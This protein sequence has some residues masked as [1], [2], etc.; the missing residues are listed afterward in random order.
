MANKVIRLQLTAVLNVEDEEKKKKL[1]EYL[2]R[3]DGETL[4]IE[5]VSKGLKMD[6]MELMSD[7]MTQKTVNVKLMM[8]E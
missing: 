8:D 7:S 2:D 4:S 3:Y 5:D 1:E 6:L